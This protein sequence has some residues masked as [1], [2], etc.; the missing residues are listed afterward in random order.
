MRAGAYTNIMAS[1][2]A[3][4]AGT[5][6]AFGFVSASASHVG[7][8]RRVNEDAC[9]ALPE[10]GLWAV[11]DGMGGHQAGDLASRTIIESLATIPAEVES[12]DVGA[13]I[14]AA[15]LRANAVLCD[16]SQRRAHGT[17]IGATV[18]ALAVHDRQFTCFWAGDSRLYRWRTGTLSQLTRDH[19]QVQDMVDTGLLTPDAAEHH[20]LSNV[21]TRAVGTHPDLLLDRI[22][23]ATEPGDIFV[24]CTDGL[25]KMVADRDIAEIVGATDVTAQPDALIEAALGQGGRDNV[26]VVCVKV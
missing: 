20:P 2:A 17:I 6:R 15:I 7:N 18:V 9:L 26:T 24:V 19:S 23:G 16:E 22:T 13:A 5:T 21:I 11:A 14:E 4:G 25:S 12:G 10:R 1:R 3:D 8:V